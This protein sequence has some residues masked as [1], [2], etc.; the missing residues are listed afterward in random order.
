MLKFPEYKSGVYFIQIQKRII[1]SSKK[2]M[3]VSKL[4]HL[5]HGH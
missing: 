1:C 2:I 5:V 4:V 3:G